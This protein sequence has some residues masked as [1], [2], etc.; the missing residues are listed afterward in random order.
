MFLQFGVKF[1][2]AYG[3]EKEFKEA[4]EKEKEALFLRKKDGGDAKIDGSM[5][6]GMEDEQEASFTFESHRDFADDGVHVHQTPKRTHDIPE[7]EEED[8]DDD[9]FELNEH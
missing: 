9:E 8:D 6:D 1:A 3:F 5:W 7:E 4:V 2:R